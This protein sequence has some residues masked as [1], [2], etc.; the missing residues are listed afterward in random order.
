MM[1][2]SLIAFAL[3]LTGGLILKI[4]RLLL[5]LTTPRNDPNHNCMRLSLPEL[6]FSFE[7]MKTY[8]FL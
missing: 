3:D 6:R 2:H 7:G 4:H 8:V 1:M 5:L